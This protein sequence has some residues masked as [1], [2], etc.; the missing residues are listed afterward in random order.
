VTQLDF[1]E[2]ECNGNAAEWHLA[3]VAHEAAALSAEAGSD[4]E[5]LGAM[6]EDARL[7]DA[8][9]EDALTRG[10]LQ[11]GCPSPEAFPALEALSGETGRSLNEL[12]DEALHLLLVRRGRL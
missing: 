8:V 5:F 1:Y 4:S 11:A 7:V 2:S 9:V 10:T 12:L 3:M 6:R